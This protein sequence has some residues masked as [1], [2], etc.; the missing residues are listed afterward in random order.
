MFNTA[1]S[2][3]ST[4]VTRILQCSYRT[5]E[6]ILVIQFPY[7]AKKILKII[8]NSKKKYQKLSIQVLTET[9]TSY[10]KVS[11][12]MLFKVYY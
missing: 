11:I 7:L 9:I 1:I 12:F 6:N 10:T 5:E 8:I 2:S 4:E 3:I